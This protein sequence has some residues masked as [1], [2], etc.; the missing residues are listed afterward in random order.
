[1]AEWGALP[2][3][4]LPIQILKYFLWV[5]ALFIA[6]F[7]W[8]YNGRETSLCFLDKNGIEHTLHLPVKDREKICGL[9]Q[10]LFAEDSFAYVLLGNKP[11]C[12][13]SYQT[14]LPFHGWANFYYSFLGHYQTLR[15]GWITWEKYRHLFP[16]FNLWAEKSELYPGWTSILLV[17]EKQFNIVVANNRKDFEGILQREIVDGS[18]LLKEAK[19]SSLIDEALQS[20]QVLLGITLG[21]GREN[22]WKFLESCETLIPAGFVWD[23]QEDIPD[24]IPEDIPSTDFYLLWFSCPSFAGDPHSE[25]SMELKTNY[26]LTKQRVMKYYKDKDFLEA[27]LSLLAGYRPQEGC[28]AKNGNRDRKGRLYPFHLKM[29]VLGDA[30]SPL[31]NDRKR[32]NISNIRPLTIVW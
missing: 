32:L 3:C 2:K 14:P 31:P 7:F 19:N 17:N 6:F 18:Q 27:T 26:L 5:W 1:M 25:E 10:K 11:M 21:Y 13:G 29:L 4:A 12:R 28:V 24:E 15:D 20:H 22:S 23:E 9:M 30:K 8:Q 16:S